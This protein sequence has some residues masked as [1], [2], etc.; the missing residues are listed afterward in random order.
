[1]TNPT[2]S[3]SYLATNP[4]YK[5][6]TIDDGSGNQVQ[7]VTS[8][9]EILPHDYIAVTYPTSTTESYVYKTGGSGGTTI[10]TVTVTYTDSTKANI[11]SVEKS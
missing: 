4:D 11:S 10:A 6:K 5:V 8:G 7:T 2:V 3:N 1:M 9:L